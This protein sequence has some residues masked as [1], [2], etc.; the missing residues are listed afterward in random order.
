MT[1]SQ[2]LGVN[3]FDLLDREIDDVILIVNFYIEL[4]NTEKPASIPNNKG[5]ERIRVN[6]KTA[7]GGWF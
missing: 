6:D 7:T 3:P 2:N 1:L 5:E 4:G